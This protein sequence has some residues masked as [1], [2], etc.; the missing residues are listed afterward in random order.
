MGVGEQAWEMGDA[1]TVEARA[2]VPG[3]LCRS[4]YFLICDINNLF[5]EFILKIRQSGEDTSALNDLTESV[6]KSIKDI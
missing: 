3:F 1:C 5:D 2:R 6:L 4:I